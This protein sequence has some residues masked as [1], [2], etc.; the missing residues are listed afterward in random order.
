[1][2]SLYFYY[3]A[4]LGWCVNACLLAAQG[5]GKSPSPS[6]S[7]TSMWT[8]SILF[9]KNTERSKRI[10]QSQKMDMNF[11][12]EKADFFFTGK[13]HCNVSIEVY[14]PRHERHSLSFVIANCGLMGCFFTS[15]SSERIR[16]FDTGCTLNS[17]CEYFL[18]TFLALVVVE[19]MLSNLVVWSFLSWL[20]VWVFNLS[21]TV[22][23]SCFISF[24]WEWNLWVEVVT[25]HSISECSCWGSLAD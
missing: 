10:V 20:I 11:K 12:I 1:M 23:G 21:L 6:L 4:C 7:P 24:V 17:V 22:L 9:K 13:V 3:R 8:M 5:T 19:I 2:Q 16:L 18:L 14:L 25:I 15:A